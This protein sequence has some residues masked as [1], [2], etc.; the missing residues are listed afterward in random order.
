M[1]RSKRSRRAIAT[2]VVLDIEGNQREVHRRQNRVVMR[3]DYDMLGSQNSS[4]QHGGRRALDAERRVG[5]ADRAWDSRGH[6]F[7]TE[8]DRLHRP[9]CRSCADGANDRTADPDR[10]V[11]FAKTNTARARR[12]TRAEPADAG[13]QELRQ[14]RSSHQSRNTTSREICCA[15]RGSWRRTTKAYRTGRQ[16]WP[17][18]RKSSEQHYLRRA[19]PADRRHLP[20]RQ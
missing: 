7:R 5:P 13:V 12:T 16:P 18:S 8:Y 3:Y 9:V 6:E 15:A 1:A 2:R 17:W 20:G 19:E 4:G 11:L 10:D 14:R